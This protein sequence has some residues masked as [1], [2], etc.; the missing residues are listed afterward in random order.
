M[1]PRPSKKARKSGASS[2]GK[3]IKY[4]WYLTLVFINLYTL[5]LHT[6]LCMFPMNAY[7]Y[8]YTLLVSASL[9]V[10]GNIIFNKYMYMYTYTYGTE[11]L[12]NIPE[13]MSDEKAEALVRNNMC[14]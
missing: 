1:D 6:F 14:Y 9:S 11:A 13:G 12:P 4:L 8:V 10:H 3:V 7:M 2:A 5:H